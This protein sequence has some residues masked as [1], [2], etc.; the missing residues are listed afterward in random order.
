MSDKFLEINSNQSEE[1]NKE[2]N[3]NGN[4][5]KEEP[6]ED[7]LSQ[8]SNE[9]AVFQMD[10][11]DD[12]DDFF[13]AEKKDTKIPK[14]ILISKKQGINLRKS[15][16]I[17]KTLFHTLLDAGILDYEN[18]QEEVENV[19]FDA[20]QKKIELMMEEAN[21]LYRNGK[22]D[23]AQQMYEE[24]SKINKK[25]QDIDYQIVK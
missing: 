1:L 24:I 8:T 25:M 9:N 12:F 3:E 20:L 15:K 11:S 2:D 19:S 6:Q 5:E 23:E 18:M 14:A 17:Q 21:E 22:A 4:I 13:V 10:F 16:D 7:F